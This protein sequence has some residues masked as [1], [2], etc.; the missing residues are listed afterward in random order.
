MQYST[1]TSFAHMEAHWPVLPGLTK[2]WGQRSFKIISGA[3][4]NGVKLA[5]LALSEH[6]EEQAVPL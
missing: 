4:Q 3:W 5:Y 1:S 6:L 2:I